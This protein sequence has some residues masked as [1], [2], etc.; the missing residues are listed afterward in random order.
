VST[1]LPAPRRLIA[2]ARDARVPGRQRALFTR[3]VVVALIA[4]LVPSLISAP[5]LLTLNLACTYAVAAV[6]LSIIFTLGGFISVAQAAV[7]ATGGYVLILLFGPTVGFPVALLLAC[8]GGAAVSALMGFAGARVKSHYFILISL[9]LAETISLV[10]TNAT[11]LTGGANGVGLKA[12]ASIAGLDLAIPL[13][14]FRWISILV[15]LAVYL[16]DS[17]R[18]SRAGLALRAQT[19]D[20][21]LA[22]AAGVTIG[23][24]RILATA[25]GGA[26][27]GIAGGM[28]AVLDSY[29]GPQNFALDTAILLLLMVV[30]AGTGR[31]GSVV[32]S[33][34]VLTFLSQGLLT[35]TAT[36]KLI[37]GIGLIALIIF[38]PEGLGGVPRAGRR[39]LSRLRAT[40]RGSAPAPR[41]EP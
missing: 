2:A 35:L 33:A 17:L 30:I 40:A 1:A 8:L 13:D 28:V 6:G 31:A 20:E 9:A 21:Y 7:M 36:G 29:L 10:L 39:L 22:L 26:F 24:Y 5:N 12:P 41:G 18:A 19:V 11:E 14:Y 3:L 23:R 34:L 15:L 38:A 37:Y 25:I 4:Q 16:A 32:V 27:G